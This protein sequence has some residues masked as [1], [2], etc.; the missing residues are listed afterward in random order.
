MIFL[1]YSQVSLAVVA[2]QIGFDSTEPISE[3]LVR[4]MILNSIRSNYMKFKHE[5]GLMVVCCDDRDYW[6]REF[7]PYYKAARRKKRQESTFDWRSVYAAMDAV[8]QELDEFFPLWVVQGKL[9]EAD[10]VIARLCHRVEGPHLILSGDGDFVQLHR[11]DVE[12]YSPIQKKAVTSTDPAAALIEKILCGDPG[13]GVPN[14]LSDDDTFMVPGKRQ[15]A[16]TKK[17]IEEYSVSVPRGIAEA[18]LVRNYKRNEQLIDLKNAP[19]HVRQSIDE[20]IDRQMAKNNTGK[21]FNYFISKHLRNLVE[22]IGDFA[23]P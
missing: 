18:R 5:Y 23:P 16:M 20:A 11:R 14:I 13:D 17:R 6:R 4:H 3:G 19:A 1:D 10:D 8:K 2:M 22:S 12:Q 21:L 7:F 9:A 15:G